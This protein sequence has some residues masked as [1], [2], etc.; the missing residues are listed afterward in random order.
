MARTPPPPADAASLVRLILASPRLSAALA[1]TSIGTAVLSFAIRQTIGW[2]GLIG[3]LAGLLALTMASLSAQRKELEWRGLLPLSLLVFVGWAGVSLFWSQYQWAT[4]AALLYLATFTMI[5]IYIALARDTIQ[6]VRAFGDVLR[7][8][9]GVSLGLEVF[10]GLLIDTPIRFLDISGDIGDFGPIQGL[11]GT[12][13]Q[14][15]LLAVMALVTFGTELLT[16]TVSRATTAFS[17]VGAAIALIL[18]RAPLAYGALVITAV[19]AAVIYGLRRAPATV[20]PYLQVATLVLTAG[21]AGIGWANRGVIVHLFNAGGDLTYRLNIW[22]HVFALVPQFPLQGWGWIGIWRDNIVPFLELSGATGRTTASSLNAYLDVWFQ[23]GL[24]GF[25]IFLGFLG[26]TFTRSW[27][28]ASRRR[29]VVFAW[30]ALTL[31][32]LLI[33]ALAESSILIEF[34]WLTLVVCSVKASREL[35]WRRAFRDEDET[36]PVTE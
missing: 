23:L 16:H 22:Q 30:P 11:L 15:G 36:M 27:L 31:V 4:L 5:G 29:N 2:A 18:T 28:L 14:L 7:V 26:L 6:I 12:R 32:V 20:R 17:L 1:T 25:L 33:G 3:V 19:A 8:V 34:G 9:L 21:F 13:N 35:S 24:V 10:S